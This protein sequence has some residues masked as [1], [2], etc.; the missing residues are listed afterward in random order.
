[1]SSVV[2]AGRCYVTDRGYAKFAFLNQ[3]NSIG[4]SCICRARNNSTPKILKERQFTDAD[5]QVGVRIDREVVLDAH[6][7]NSKTV[8]TDYPGCNCLSGG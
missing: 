7:S 3:I 4:S 6:T 2:Q 8:P 1:M 5:R